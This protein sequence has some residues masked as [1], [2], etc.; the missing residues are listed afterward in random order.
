[1]GNV[2][3][4][5]VVART[6]STREATAVPPVLYRA[7]AVLDWTEGRLTLGCP[8]ACAETYNQAYRFG[9]TMGGARPIV[10]VDTT[11]YFTGV[12]DGRHD[13]LATL[14]RHLHP[15]TLGEPLHDRVHK[16][17]DLLQAPGRNWVVF[18][19]TDIGNEWVFVGDGRLTAHVLVTP[20][21]NGPS[22]ETLEAYGY[23]RLTDEEE[24]QR[25]IEQL[26]RS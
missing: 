5:I 18:R 20:G 3:S 10:R 15:E 23:R 25:G 14:E 21:D 8:S 12:L 19:S 9:G 13:G 26:G 6:K 17:V 1:M 16:S 7:H 11:G 2:S 4:K 22:V 24:E